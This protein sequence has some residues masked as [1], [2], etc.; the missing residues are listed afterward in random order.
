MDVCNAVS[1][2]LQGRRLSTGGVNLGGEQGK[3]LGAY[4]ED[5]YWGGEGVVCSTLLDVLVAM[6]RAMRLGG[7]DPDTDSNRAMANGPRNFKN[8]NFV[9]QRPVEF[10]NFSLLVVGNRFMLRLV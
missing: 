3:W 5:A 9:K 1:M 10:S 6:Y 2:H 4:G 8:Q 7:W